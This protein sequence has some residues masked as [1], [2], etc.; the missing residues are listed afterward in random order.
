[1]QQ[2][3]NF[4]MFPAEDPAAELE[5]VIY[6]VLYKPMTPPVPEK[7]RELL[8]V[9]QYHKGPSNPRPL[10]QLAAKLQANE[11]EVKQLAKTLTEEYG[12][13]VGANRQPPYGYYLCVTAEH[14]RAAKQVYIDEIISL[15]RRARALDPEMTVLELKG[16]GR[17][18]FDEEKSA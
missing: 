7:I 8:K 18:V 6:D 16:Q 4:G 3:L 2:Q 1:M 5:R 13:P 17:I 11:R 9:L 14:R 15:A 12:V 10:E